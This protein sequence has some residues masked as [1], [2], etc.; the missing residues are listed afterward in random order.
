MEKYI[1]ALETIKSCLDFT[2]YWYLLKNM[3]IQVCKVVK[4]EL[5]A[6]SF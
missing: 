4:F 1:S 6:G 5:K 3:N 2:K